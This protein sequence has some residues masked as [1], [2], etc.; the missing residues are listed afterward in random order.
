MYTLKPKFYL[1]HL[2]IMMFSEIAAISISS[3]ITH[4][5]YLLLLFFFYLF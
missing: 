1:H 3:L 4:V 5:F 2:L